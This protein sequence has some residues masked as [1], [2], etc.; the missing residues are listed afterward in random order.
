MAE[1]GKRSRAGTKFEVWLSD[2]LRAD[3]R[4]GASRDGVHQTDWVRQA[5]A[6]KAGRGAAFERY[7]ALAA[8]VAA[9]RDEIRELRAGIDP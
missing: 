9:V 5:I 3:V 8:E 1:M 2:E 6:A 4:A 7:S